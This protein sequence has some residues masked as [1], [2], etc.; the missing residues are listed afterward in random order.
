MAIN[1]SVKDMDKYKWTGYLHKLEEF[2]E[3]NGRKP[4]MGSD[5]EEEADVARWMNIQ[6][7]NKN[8]K[9]WCMKSQWM[10][11]LSENERYFIV[12]E[13]NVWCKKLVEVER[14]IDIYNKLPDGVLGKW[15]NAQF[16]SNGN[17]KEEWKE[18]MGKHGRY[19][20]KDE[21]SVIND[22]CECWED[23]CN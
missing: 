6:Q 15:I 9:E 20:K 10:R 7:K 1:P 14:F 19:F 23:M 2:I 12:K 11:F 13:G 17:G 5:C 22:T 3:S 21:N 16:I 8:N 18:F 4:S